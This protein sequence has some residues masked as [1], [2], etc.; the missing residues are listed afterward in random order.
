MGEPHLAVLRLSPGYI[1]REMYVVPGIK[2]RQAAWKTSARPAV[3]S[4]QPPRRDI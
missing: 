4:L 3:P 2:P 1:L